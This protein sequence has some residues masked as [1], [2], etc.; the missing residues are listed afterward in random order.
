VIDQVYLRSDCLTE[1]I[2]VMNALKA[3]FY[4]TKSINPVLVASPYMI[5]SI[6]RSLGPDEY[7]EQVIELLVAELASK[8]VTL[9]SYCMP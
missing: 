4:L 3:V 8:A 7:M 2:L 1:S 6:T 5:T 9:N